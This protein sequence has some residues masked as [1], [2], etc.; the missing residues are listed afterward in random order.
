M[1][2]HAQNRKLFQLGVSTHYFFETVQ[3][4][5]AKYLPIKWL[6]IPEYRTYHENHK[7]DQLPYSS[8]KYGINR[9]EIGP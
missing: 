4:P 1:F 3:S 9:S 7:Y 2:I 6:K 5:L 8:Y